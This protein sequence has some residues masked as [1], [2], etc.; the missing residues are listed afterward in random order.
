MKHPIILSYCTIISLADASLE[1]WGVVYKEQSFGGPWDDTYTSIDELELATILV[2]LEIL[3]V[4]TRSANLRVFCDNTVAIA[5][6]NHM[7]GKVSRL[8]VIA[9]RIWD[10]L[11]R[12]DAFLTATYVPSAQNVADPLTRGFTA[13]TRRFFDLEVQLNPNV[14]KTH[15]VNHGP[16]SPVFD[17]FASCHNKQL[18]RF[19]AWQEGTQG[20]ECIDAFQQDWSRFPG[21]MFPPFSL[22]PKV[23]KKIR[24]EHAKM[25]LVHPNWPGALWGPTLNSKNLLRI[26]DYLT[27]F[28]LNGRRAK[29][30]VFTFDVF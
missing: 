27:I 3:P 10:L 30:I 15:I 25:V 17:W 28:P 23:L 13:K 12:H 20:A 9:R 4:L 21:Y 26:L 2:A 18:P 22:L 11:E 19:C 5:Y 7:G 1:G 14:F 24:D 16:F 6:V 8:N 29:K